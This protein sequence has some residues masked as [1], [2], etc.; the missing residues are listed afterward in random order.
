MMDSTPA[1]LRR[2]KPYTTLSAQES[3][4][5]SIKCGHPFGFRITLIGEWKKRKQFEWQTFHSTPRFAKWEMKSGSW[6]S[7]ITQLHKKVTLVSSFSNYWRRSCCFLHTFLITRRQRQP[8]LAPQI[9]ESSY[10]VDSD[11]KKDEGEGFIDAK[12]VR[13]PRVGQLSCSVDGHL[14]HLFERSFQFSQR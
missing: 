4:R 5:S 9:R 6:K 3:T 14:L 8:M 12:S 7:V 1:L 13:Q 2:S 10:P 11:V